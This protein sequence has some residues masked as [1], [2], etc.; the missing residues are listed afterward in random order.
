MSD[1]RIPVFPALLGALFSCVLG[2][3]ALE[4][5]IYEN[6]SGPEGFGT[7]LDMPFGACVAQYVDPRDGNEYLVRIRKSNPEMAAGESWSDTTMLE[8]LR[9][10]TENSECLY[11]SVDC[12]G[13]GRV[14]PAGDLA[15]ACPPGWTPI[16]LGHGGWKYSR[17]GERKIVLDIDRPFATSVAFL[18]DSVWALDDGLSISRDIWLMPGG[19]RTGGVK[20]VADGGVAE[21]RGRN[22]MWASQDSLFVAG[23]GQSARAACDDSA[24]AGF[25]TDNHIS[26]DDWFRWSECREELVCRRDILDR[27]DL[28]G[29][30][31]RIWGLRCDDLNLSP[32]FHVKRQSVRKA[33]VRCGKGTTPPLQRTECRNRGRAGASQ[34]APSVCDGEGIGCMLFQ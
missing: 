32:C 21:P 29:V 20:Y 8:N 15:D 24:S 12:R 4:C 30:P 6:G 23:Y 22:L 5:A 7:R 28:S 10:R 11:D 31:G 25:A 3:E 33:S 14:Y 9:Y 26:P 2:A 13:Y 17:Y 34:T 27:V 18:R 16:G 1:S 19:S